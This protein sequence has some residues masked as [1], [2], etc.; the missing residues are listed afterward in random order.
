MGTSRLIY[1]RMSLFFVLFSFGFFILK[2]IRIPGD[3]V[4]MRLPDITLHD[5][6][7]FNAENFINFFGLIAL[8]NITYFASSCCPGSMTIIVLM[9][10]SLAMC[11]ITFCRCLCHIITYYEV[12]CYELIADVV[13]VTLL[14]ISKPI[15]SNEP[16][17]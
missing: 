12:T 16:H 6:I 11:I 4:I 1:I 10:F 3:T 8:T 17:T 9:R 14:F 5:I 7:Y 2:N 13:L 15:K